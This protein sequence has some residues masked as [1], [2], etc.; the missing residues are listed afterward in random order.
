MKTYAE[1]ACDNLDLIQTEIYTFLIND[2]ELLTNGEKNWQFLDTK[3]L[4]SQ[5]PNLIKFFLANNLYVQQ[6]SVTLL[7]EDLP[8]HLDELPMI[9]K[10]NIPIQN[11]KGWVNRWYELSE[12][13]IAKLPKMKN[14]FGSEQEN[15]SVLV[16]QELKLAAEMLLTLEGNPH[17]YYG[18]EIGMY[19]YKS[20]GPFWDETRRLP[21]KWGNDFTTSWH[22]DT[23][24]GTVASIE[25]QFLDPD[26]L[27]NVYKNV[28]RTRQISPALRYG[29]V[30]ESEY[31]NNALVSYYRVLNHDENHQYKVLVVHNVSE[32]EYQ[33][34]EIEGTILYYSNG[35][36]NYEG[37]VSPSSTLIIEVPY[38][39]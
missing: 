4:I 18:E 36:R 21:L 16:E 28:M 37:T 17:L 11:T 34:G 38:S 29:E 12:E 7:Y 1:L 27:L 23:I 39:E 14:Q 2:T 33:L 6:A 32:Y 8:L 5:S 22:P 13:E 25:D 24:N 15:V 30:V 19:G 20:S 10:V 26:S 35:L 31:S 3:K 9:A